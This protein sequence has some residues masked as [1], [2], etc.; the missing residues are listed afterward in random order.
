ATEAGEHGLDRVVKAGRL[1]RKST[2]FGERA[3]LVDVVAAVERVEHQRHRPGR[4]RDFEA[5]VEQ[6]LFDKRAAH[7]RRILRAQPLE[8]RKLVAGVVERPA[9]ENLAHVDLGLE[10]QR[11]AELINR[12]GLAVATEPDYL[13]HAGKVAIEEIHLA[14]VDHEP[15]AAVHP[16]APVAEAGDEPLGVAIVKL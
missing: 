11:M 2:A 10:A 1:D 3:L 7:R 14:A 4:D 5:G 13:A 15:A 9:K 6:M 12:S 16:L 8:P